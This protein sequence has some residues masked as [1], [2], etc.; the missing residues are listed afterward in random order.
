MRQEMRSTNSASVIVWT[1]LVAEINNGD[2]IRSSEP[3]ADPSRADF[4]G[5]VG[6]AVAD[7]GTEEGIWVE[8]R[9]ESGF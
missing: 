9:E 2:L 6:L 7:T 8:G 5:G 3:T 4:L 1:N